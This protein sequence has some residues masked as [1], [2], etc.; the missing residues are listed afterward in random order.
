MELLIRLA[1]NSDLPEY[2]DL[3]QK[4]YEQ[5]YTDPSIGLTKECFSREIFFNSDTQTYLRSNIVNTNTQRCWVAYV[6]KELV[7][8][9]TITLNSGEAEAKGFY[10]APERQGQGIGK[11]LWDK[12][13][14]FAGNRDIVL[15]LYAHNQKTLAMYRSWGFVIDESKGDKGVFYRHWPEWP[16]GL[17]AKCFYMRKAKA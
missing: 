17:Q 11:K 14:E 6:G 10:V 12:A 16:D 3:L 1:E 5:A 13:I 2:T 8:S 15:D 4:T 9:I 7:G